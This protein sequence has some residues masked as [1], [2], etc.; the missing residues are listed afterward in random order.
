MGNIDWIEYS[1]EKPKL[2]ELV[3]I[4]R[5]IESK[6]IYSNVWNEEEERF[7]DWNQITHWA[8]INYPNLL[9]Q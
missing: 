3:L 8:H 9:T 6:M 4:Y 1:K 2:G 5:D 7:A